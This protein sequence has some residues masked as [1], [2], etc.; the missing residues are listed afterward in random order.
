MSSL[1]IC[2]KLF[3]DLRIFVKK[4][5]QNCKICKLLSFKNKTIQI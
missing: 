2:K 4:Y 1:Q 3:T 5:L